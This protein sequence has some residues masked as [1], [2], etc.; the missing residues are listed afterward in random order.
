MWGAVPGERGGGST[1]CRL[2]EGSVPARL[3]SRGRVHCQPEPSPFPAV[4]GL[5]PG[6]LKGPEG[7]SRDAATD[8]CG[9]V[10]PIPF[11]RVLPVLSLGPLQLSERGSLLWLGLGIM[12]FPI[13]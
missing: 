6:A 3:C 5:V 7:L 11:H 12:G 2:Q 9:H 4:P 1:G 13:L 8:L 10:A